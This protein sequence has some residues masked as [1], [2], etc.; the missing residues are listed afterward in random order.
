MEKQDFEMLQGQKKW[1]VVHGL[2]KNLGAGQYITNKQVV[3]ALFKKYP[4]FNRHP[5][6]IMAADFCANSPSGYDKKQSNG[7]YERSYKPVLFKIAYNQYIRYNP[8]V[9]GLWMCKIIN[10]RKKV[11]K[12]LP[13]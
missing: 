7:S 5:N 4:E 9:H 6:P 11:L 12:I 13:S 3:V 1:N 2:V 10:G 8:Q